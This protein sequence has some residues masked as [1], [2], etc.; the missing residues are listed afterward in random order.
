MLVLMTVLL[1]AAVGRTI[2]DIEINALAIQNRIIMLSLHAY[3]LHPYMPKF[4]AKKAKLTFSWPL[5]L[6]GITA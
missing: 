5:T 4:Y 2:R 1:E 3:I 6:Q